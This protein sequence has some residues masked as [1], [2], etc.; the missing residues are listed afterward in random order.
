MMLQT[1]KAGLQNVTVRPKLTSKVITERLVYPVKAVSGHISQF[2]CSTIQQQV[3]HRLLINS[4]YGIIHNLTAW[5]VRYI[6]MLQ[7]NLQ[8]P[9]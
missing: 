6:Q 3:R 7:Y 2:T 4:V 1:S 8:L 9:V 5:L